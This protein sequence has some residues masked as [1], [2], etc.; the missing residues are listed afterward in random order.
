M[1]DENQQLEDQ[2][3]LMDA[4]VIEQHE[5]KTNVPEINI[6]QTPKDCPFLDGYPLASQY[7]QLAVRYSAWV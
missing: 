6:Q 3:I 1:I 7:Q 2:N 5:K 4:D